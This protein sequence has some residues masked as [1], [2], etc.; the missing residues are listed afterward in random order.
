M[1]IKDPHV[2]HPDFPQPLSESQ[3]RTTQEMLGCRAADLVAHEL[4]LASLDGTRGT[5]DKLP[6]VLQDVSDSARLSIF[7]CLE[8][9]G[10]MPHFLG[11]G[12][13]REGK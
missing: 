10:K 3:L 2:S 5:M 9:G 11:D 13:E 12:V 8:W 1:S 7:E 4:L 6:G